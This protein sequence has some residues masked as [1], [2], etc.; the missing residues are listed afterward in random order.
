MNPDHLASDAFWYRGLRAFCRLSLENVS[1][2][3]GLAVARIAQLEQG[4]GRPPADF[5]TAV[6]R[7]FFRRWMT[8]TVPQA[9]EWLRLDNERSPELSACK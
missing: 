5:E 8:E 2:A 1:T 4:R 6:L 3:T 7:G 9:P